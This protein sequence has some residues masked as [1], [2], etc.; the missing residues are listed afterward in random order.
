MKRSHALALSGAA[1]FLALATPSYAQSFRS[2][3]QCV[4]AVVDVSMYQ[5][6]RLHLVQGQ[7]VC[8]CAVR[9][10]ALRRMDRLRGED[11]SDAVTGSISARPGIGSGVIGAGRG[12]GGAVTGRET[13]GP[14]VG[15]SVGTGAAGAVGGNSGPSRGGAVADNDT[16]GPGAGPGGQGGTGGGRGG[17]GASNGNNGN[18]QGPGNKM[19]S[20][21]DRNRPTTPTPT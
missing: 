12:T 15:G 13:S 9:P 1:L 16:S 7:E 5:N 4:P 18:G 17:N 21:T 10:Q 2:G 11:R 19:A 3:Q 14:A 8:R 20:A 6:C